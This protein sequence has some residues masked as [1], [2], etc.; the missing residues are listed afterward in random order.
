MINK[1]F[2]RFLKVLPKRRMHKFV[3]QKYI[4]LVKTTVLN[5]LYCPG[6]HVEDGRYW[7]SELPE[8]A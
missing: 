2:R 3:Y 6:P 4:E 8:K 1:Y 7:S 5:S